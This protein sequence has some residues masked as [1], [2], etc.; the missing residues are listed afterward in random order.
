MLSQIF[1]PAFPRPSV[2][3][4]HGGMEKHRRTDTRA[5]PFEPIIQV[6]ERR[7][8]EDIQRLLQAWPKEI[9]DISVAGRR[10]TVRR[11]EKALR[12]ER[13]RGRAG[14]WTYDVARHHQLARYLRAEQAALQRCE[15]FE[16]QQHLVRKSE[17]QKL[18]ARV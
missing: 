16:R 15:S 12:Q 4:D 7:R 2:P 13:C 17:A 10:R 18:K 11:L 3:S 1:C 8:C 14:H 9:A 5:Q 6:N